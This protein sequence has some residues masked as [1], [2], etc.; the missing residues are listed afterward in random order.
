MGLALANGD[1][2]VVVHS[3][4]AE[5]A[6]LVL[7]IE[8]QGWPVDGPVQLVHRSG[9]PLPILQAAERTA[10]ES[11]GQLRMLVVD[12][13][14]GAA[15]PEIHDGGAPRLA[16]LGA[17]HWT[18]VVIDSWAV[19]GGLMA[20]FGH[21]VLAADGLEM[22][23][24]GAWGRSFA[25]DHLLE[26]VQRPELLARALAAAEGLA[27]PPPVLASLRRRHETRLATHRQAVRMRQQML[28]RSGP[29]PGES[30]P[31]SAERQADGRVNRLL[32]H[33]AGSTQR[34]VLVESPDFEPLRWSGDPG[35]PPAGLAQILTPGR[36][37]RLAT[38]LQAGVPQAVRLGVPAT[39]A[40][41]MM[42]L[43]LDRCL[44][45]ASLLD[46]AN[47]TREQIRALTSLEVP[48]SF[49]FQQ[50]YE[51]RMMAVQ[52]RSTVV[53]QVVTGRLNGPELE[54]SAALLGWRGGSARVVAY[55]C[56]VGPGP[57]PAGGE[58]FDR[59]HRAGVTAG[60]AGEATVALVRPGEVSGLRPLLEAAARPGSD[61]VVLG[62]GTEVSVPSD[63]ARSYREAAM[64]ARIA[65][66]L[67]RDELSFDS[68][69]IHRLFLPGAEAGDADF[70]EP[71]S[72]L[73]EAAATMTFDPV[74]TLGAYLDTGCSIPRAAQR[75]QVHPNSLRYRLQRI[76]TASG[77]DLDDPE[78]RFRA[79]LAIRLRATRRVLAGD[80]EV[81][82]WGRS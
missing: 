57:A 36:L 78:E 20:V 58:P 56:R 40:R 76:A 18:C 16:D 14:R 72:R 27:L 30:A 21:D 3:G 37:S 4:A 11:V 38:A 31:G 74:E 67:G 59:W 44:G 43:G 34:A 69:G 17:R 41:L 15:C 24:S 62:V 75:L 35:S 54:R 29:D 47:P 68:L 13:G 19:T 22:D 10:S 65:V 52:L 71:L 79:Q 9:G 48:L 32:D 8:E 66:A 23:L 73:E 7:A 39:G 45:Y 42:R 82:E 6:G 80:P 12:S 61:R 28:E 60:L 53:S 77:L 5:G 25:L 81:T 50:E 33:V 70:E 64:A 2:V 63:A 51:D 1:R 55:A 26:Q 46:V 49:A